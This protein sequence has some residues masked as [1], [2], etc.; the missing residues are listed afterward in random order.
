MKNLEQGSPIQIVG[1]NAHIFLDTDTI[2]TPLTPS[3]ADRAARFL[4]MLTPEAAPG[5][6]V[7]AVSASV[8]GVTERQPIPSQE[9][10]RKPR[11]AT[12]NPDEGTRTPADWLA[13]ECAELAEIVENL[14]AERVAQHIEGIPASLEEAQRR[15]HAA[16]SARV[17]IQTIA[18]TLEP[19]KRLAA[20]EVAGAERL[21]KLRPK[22]GKGAGTEGAIRLWRLLHLLAVYKAE[23][24]DHKPNAAQETV[25]TANE[26][27]AAALRVDPKTIERW[28]EQLQGM[29][30]IDTREHKGEHLNTSTGELETRNTGTVYAVAL[31]PG[32]VARLTYA[33]LHYRYR[34]L[35]ADRAAGRTAYRYAK[36][37]KALYNA[38]KNMSESS[39]FPGGAAGDAEQTAFRVC[40]AWAVTPGG[41]Q[42]FLD[43]RY[44][45]DPDIFRE[46]EKTSM[47]SVI[48]DL[49]LI[50]DEADPDRRR[51]LVHHTAASIA[52][53]LD[54]DHSR[55]YY[56]GLIWQAIKG[57]WKGLQAL[58]AQLARFEV[59]RSEWGSH[60]RHAPAL[61]TSRTRA[62]A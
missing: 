36:Q 29:G 27:L 48:Y 42:E 21:E 51:V 49:P 26:L 1:Q 38:E 14:E 45:L 13:R 10:Q 52:A 56:A 22:R 4:A 41:G 43:P 58:A 62:T 32:H 20:D 50:A 40:Q 11:E 9:G 30:L 47:Q 7:G 46:D 19:T 55:S 2:K 24:S 31:Q 12:S 28:N 57:G 33:D 25:H 6:L 60:M 34:N 16:Q 18:A 53:A 37:I 15:L 3:Q 61:L 44:S 39:A 59:D 8:P 35:D 17:H 5:A 54:D 23:R